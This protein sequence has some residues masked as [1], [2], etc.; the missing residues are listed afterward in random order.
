LEG[1]REWVGP[2]LDGYRDLFAAVDEQ[3]ISLAW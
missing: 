2:R 1:L 3:G